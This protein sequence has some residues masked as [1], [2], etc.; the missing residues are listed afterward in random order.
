MPFNTLRPHRISVRVLSY[1]HR[2]IEAYEKRGIVHAGGERDAA[3]VNGSWHVMPSVRIVN[4]LIVFPLRSVA[5]EEL[6]SPMQLFPNA[7]SNQW[8]LKAV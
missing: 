3:F 4:Q 5:A 6:T 1:N 2:A 7:A 8:V